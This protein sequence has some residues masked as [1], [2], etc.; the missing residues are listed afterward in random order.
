MEI[1]N[2][3]FTPKSIGILLL[4]AVLFLVGIKQLINSYSEMQYDQNISKG[5]VFFHSGNYGQAQYKFSRALKIQDGEVGPIALS[6]K[7]QLFKKKYKDAQKMYTQIEEFAFGEDAFAGQIGN[8]VCQLYMHSGSG[9]KNNAQLY[10]SLE[11]KIKVLSSDNPETTDFYIL[12][13]HLFLLQSKFFKRNNDADKA[14]S[15]MKL[16][17]EKFQKAQRLLSESAP[18]KMSSLSLYAGLGE[19]N[20]WQA[21]YVLKQTPF[22]KEGSSAAT[23]IYKK[24]LSSLTYYRTAFLYRNRTYPNIVL[25]IGYIFDELLSYPWLTE[26]QRNNVMQL[27]ANY[28]HEV[29]IFAKHLY[30]E[31]SRSRKAQ[32]DL[33]LDKSRAYAQHGTGVSHIYSKSYSK[34]KFRLAK[35]YKIPPSSSNELYAQS[36]NCKMLIKQKISKQEVGGFLDGYSKIAGRILGKKKREEEFT[37]LDTIALANFY[38]LSALARYS[39]AV[40]HVATTTKLISSLKEKDYIRNGRRLSSKRILLNNLYYLCKRDERLKKYIPKLRKYIIK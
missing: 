37:E 35:Q 15:Y 34:A 22:P 39:R 20:Y 3:K 21:Q 16:A 11:S 23:D 28:E 9:A 2:Y 26:K 10:R 8:I 30:I 25:N 13:G 12:H 31:F 29:K 7:M 24:L 17:L 4:G 18:S 36:M 40:V 38:Y 14:L 27:A 6:A 32:Q 1:G 19:V 33:Q 5:L